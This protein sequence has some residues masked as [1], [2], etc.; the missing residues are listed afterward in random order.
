MDH[1]SIFRAIIENDSEAIFVRDIEGRYLV[2][3]TFLANMVQKTVEE[4]IGR[5]PQELYDKQN[6]E[7][8]DRGFMETMESGMTTYAEDCYIHPLDGKRW[9]RTYRSPF[10]DADGK[11]AG[12]MAVAREI[13]E[14][15]RLF[16]LDALKNR[17]HALFA[18]AVDVSSYAE[19]L[20][21]IL[22][23]DTGCRVMSLAVRGPYRGES[24]IAAT[25]FDD[26]PVDADLFTRLPLKWKGE[27]L[28]CLRYIL[29]ADDS[30]SAETHSILKS[31]RPLMNEALWRFSIDELLQKS[32][33]KLKS[34]VDG[35]PL[36][37]WIID[38]DHRVDFQNEAHA[39]AF[40]RSPEGGRCFALVHGRDE[41]CESCRLSECIEGRSLRYEW[42]D[43]GSGRTYDILNA[44][45]RT[46]DGRPCQM[47]IFIDVTQRVEAVAQLRQ[48][49]RLESL[50][51]LSAGIAHDFNNV[52]AGVIG[53]AQ[54]GSQ[55][56]QTND[57][58]LDLFQQITSIAERGADLTRKILAFSRRQT[59][60]VRPVDVNAVVEDMRTMIRPLAGDRVRLE[61]KTSPEL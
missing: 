7:T 42:R 4:M 18:H 58:S 3:S 31:V 59:L 16:R 55:R 61:I 40:G 57:E 56:S 60:K 49:Q 22:T 10:R 54:L 6:A 24:V 19:G 35:I 30:E 1:D 23:E 52:L 14:E 53:Y 37:I 8:A 46:T 47:S 5:T 2:V 51:S 25:G 36:A 48:T 13:T 34:V 41:P 32:S 28:G 12:I 29:N 21:N 44:P 33:T 15:K 27:E 17:M 45:Y 11:V 20:V 50:G 43:P 26:G 38:S 9:F 39:A